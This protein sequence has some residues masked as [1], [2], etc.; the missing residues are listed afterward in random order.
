MKKKKI[1]DICDISKIKWAEI[2]GHDKQVLAL[3]IMEYIIQMALKGKLRVDILIW[4]KTDSRHNIQQRDDDEN[5]RRMY[6]HL[7][8]NVMGK[9]WPIG[10]CWKLRPD[11]NNRVDWERLKEI[12]N[13]KGK[14]LSSTLYGLKPKFHVVDIQESTPSDYPL[15]NVADL[16]VGMVRYSWEKSEKVKE[17][18]KEKEKTKH[19]HEKKTK[20]SGVDRHRCELIIDFYKKCKENKLGVSLKSSRGGLK[21][22]DPEKPVNFWLY[23]PQ[24]EKDKAP[25][26]D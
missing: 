19:Q 6:Y 9:R 24:S 23:E 10:S 14:E 20:L 25:T 15:I 1:K 7:F 4:D 18:L 16:F 22:H 3:E 11:R 17:K 12:L 2:K 5:L 21:T 8:N 13:S 26:K